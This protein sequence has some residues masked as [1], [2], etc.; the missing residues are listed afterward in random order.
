MGQEVTPRDL[1]SQHPDS[2]A[3]DRLQT[4]PHPD[5]IW[6]ALRLVRQRATQRGWDAKSQQQLPPRGQG[7]RKGIREPCWQAGSSSRRVPRTRWGR[8]LTQGPP[9]LDP[10]ILAP[11]TPRFQD[12]ARQAL[13][14]YRGS[15]SVSPNTLE[16]AELP[17]SR[18]ETEQR[19]GCQA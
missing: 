18:W 1:V 6:A 4:A 13:H 14:R 15:A 17:T 16:A 12:R 11:G 8:R 3:R 19:R 2:Q 5:F 9:D 7:A 10:D